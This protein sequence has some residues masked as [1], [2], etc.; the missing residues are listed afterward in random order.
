MGEEKRASLVAC[1]A[2]LPDPR[3]VGRADH[4]PLDIVILALC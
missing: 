3:V 2:D 1:F 4:D